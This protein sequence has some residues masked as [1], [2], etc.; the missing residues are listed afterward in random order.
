MGLAGYLHLCLPSS[1]AQIT[2]AYVT[3]R[4][5]SVETVLRENTENPLDDQTMVTQQLEQMAT[6]GRCVCRGRRR[7]GLQRIN[8]YSII[9]RQ[10]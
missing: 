4:L 8:E 2:K 7:E 6:I 9:K 5:E 1:P 3:S 10:Q